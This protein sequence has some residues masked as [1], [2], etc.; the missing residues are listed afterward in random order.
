MGYYCNACKSDISEGEYEYSKNN[1]GR[2]LCRKHQQNPN[3]KVNTPTT[4]AKLLAEALRKRGWRLETEKQADFKTVDI[5]I[6]DAKVN[7]EVD[8]IHHNFSKVQALADLKRTDYSYG[9][10][11]V[12]LR[13]PNSLVRDRPTLKETADLISKFLHKNTDELEED[14]DF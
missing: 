10:G 14:D 2:A 9:K 3:A 12:T 6:P 7:I 1:F 4:E 11:W 5:S 13:I 8:G